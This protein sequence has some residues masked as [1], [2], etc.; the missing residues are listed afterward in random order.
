MEKLTDAIHSITDI[1]DMLKI[2]S[3]VDDAMKTHPD[4]KKYYARLRVD[5]LK[6]SLLEYEDSRQDI[7]NFLDTCTNY[8]SSHFSDE[9]KFVTTNKM[10]YTFGDIK[11]S[12]HL[13]WRRWDNEKILEVSVSKGDDTC[14]YVA[15]K[16]RPRILGEVFSMYDTVTGNGKNI[17]KIR[18]I[19]GLN[20]NSFA[21]A[22]MLHYMAG[23]DERFHCGNSLLN[24]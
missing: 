7:S 15:K 14:T 5:K 10:Y 6:R 18:N 16:G 9:F 3:V 1:N 11:I 20:I 22:A 8:G 21:L 23:T 17:D 13:Q 4:R 2:Q 12:T 24:P 19:T